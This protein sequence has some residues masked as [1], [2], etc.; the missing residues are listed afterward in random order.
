MIRE[1]TTYM[2]RKKVSLSPITV[3]VDPGKDT[4]VAIF[5]DKKLVELKTFTPFTFILWLQEKVKEKEITM[6]VFENSKL[7]SHIFTVISANK[8]RNIGQGVGG[9]IGRNIGQVDGFCEII[10][11][12]C[13]FYK[14]ECKGVSPLAKGKKITHKTFIDFVPYYNKQTNQ[15]ERDA[16]QVVMR[17]NYEYLQQN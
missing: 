4:G 14:I 3:G 11:E 2:D 16:A 15:H 13:E 1:G 8:R 9:R 17:F 7:Q 5:K 6:V 10:K 12:M